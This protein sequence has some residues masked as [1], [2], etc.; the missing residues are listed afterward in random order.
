VALASLGDRLYVVNSA[1]RNIA[2]IEGGSVRSIIPLEWHPSDIAADTSS[3]RL[4]VSFTTEARL[5]SIEGEKVANVWSLPAVAEALVARDG[6]VYVGLSSEE[7]VVVLDGTTGEQV[8]RIPLEGVSSVLALALAPRNHLLFANGYGVTYK[9]SLDDLSVSL[10]SELASYRTAAVDEERG[11]LYL[12]YFDSTTASSWLAVTDI[13]SG[14]VLA[15]LPLGCDP[16]GIAVDEASGLVYVAN[17]CSH[18][19]S[20][21]DGNELKVVGTVPVGLHPLDVALAPQDGTLFVANNE[22]HS[23]SVVRKGQVVDL[24]PLAVYVNELAVDT[25]THRVYA[26]SLSTDSLFILEGDQVKS[27]GV[28]RCPHSVAVDPE[29]GVAYTADFLSKAVSVIKEGKVVETFALPEAPRAIAFN[30]V[31]GLLYAGT[32]IIDVNTGEVVGSVKLQPLGPGE[33]EPLK[34]VVSGDGERLFVKA[35]NG[36]PGSNGGFII[37]VVDAGSGE[38]LYLGADG[39][40]VADFAL[41]EERLFSS[42]S[43]FGKCS[44]YVNSLQDYEEVASIEMPC[45]LA[46][47]AY[48]PATGHLFVVRNEALYP[49]DNGSSELIVLD[50]SSLKEVIRL[51]LEGPLGPMAVDPSSNLVYVFNHRDGSVLAILDTPQ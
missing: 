47:L 21:I 27:V 24:I 31:K 44:L 42:A 8:A 9:I 2:L 50:G 22:S 48:N 20:I 29:G 36:V 51:N 35:L 10:F 32:S 3:G 46:Y 7:G 26:V 23:I 13:D 28:G 43:R 5:L 34:S 40:S 4:Y 38:Q 15:S 14:E 19:V 18:D 12:G 17:S 33:V 30:P 41:S 11:Y 45:H 6:R 49:W 25:A 37:Y 1:S 39:F 16:R